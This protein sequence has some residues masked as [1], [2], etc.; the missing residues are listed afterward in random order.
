MPKKV[1]PPSAAALSAYFAQIGSAGGAVTG[2]SK[3][4]GN[5]ALYRELQ[6]KAAASRK[7]NNAAR[8]KAEGAKK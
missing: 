7:A 1:K 6:L 4:R 2:E 3:K 5:K 8:A